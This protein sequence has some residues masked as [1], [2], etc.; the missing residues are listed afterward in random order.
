METE[1]IKEIEDLVDEMGE[2]YDYP[3]E[4]LVEKMNQL[5]G[6]EWD[7][8]TYWEYT[9]EYWS[10]HSLEETVY[11]LLHDGEY[12]KKET[13]NYYVWNAKASLEEVM[14]DITENNAETNILEETHLFFRLGRYRE[15][16][17]RFEKFNNLPMKEIYQWFQENFSQWEQRISGDEEEGNSLMLSFE[18]DYGIE[19]NIL[20]F[21]YKEK[22]LGITLTNVEEK[23]I[24]NMLVYL[25]PLITD[26]YQQK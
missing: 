23:D 18:V 19:R 16:K 17:K 4:E 7:A 12:P 10:H 24:K 11:A 21:P 1:K 25:K 22:C 14:E 5:I 13:V 3:E 6:Q 26:M 9:C 20:L 15:D 8:Q 2:C